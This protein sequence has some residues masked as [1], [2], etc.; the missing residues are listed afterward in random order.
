[1]RSFR[2]WL[3]NSHTLMELQEMFKNICKRLP[4]YKNFNF[5]PYQLAT[6]I[7]PEILLKVND[8][9]MATLIEML[10]A[11]KKHQHIVLV[12]GLMENIAVKHFLE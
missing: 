2:Q 9:Y 10:L 11:T 8:H 1:M 5:S 4:R 3:A 6:F 12:C 7:Y